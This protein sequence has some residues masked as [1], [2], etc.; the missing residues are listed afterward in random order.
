MD[1]NI[2]A[3]LAGEGYAEKYKSNKW[4]GRLSL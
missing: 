1:T 2:I 4:I 3:K